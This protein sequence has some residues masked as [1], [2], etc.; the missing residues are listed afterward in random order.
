MTWEDAITVAEI[1]TGQTWPHDAPSFNFGPGLLDD[2][3][4]FD[5]FAFDK[6]TELLVGDVPLAV[7]G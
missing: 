1:W 3:R 7:E 2:F 4:P 5:K 6:R